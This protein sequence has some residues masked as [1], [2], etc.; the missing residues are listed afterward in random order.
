MKVIFLQ[1]VKGQGKANEVKEVSDGYARNYLFPNQLAKPA[2]AGA[3]KVLNL[4]KQIQAEEDQLAVAEMRQ[5]KQ[6]L[7]ELKPVFYLEVIN[8]KAQGAIT[9]KEVVSYLQE[10]EGVELSTKQLKNFN[11]L[12]ELGTF[13]VEI[14]LPMQ[15]KASL[16][17]M[18]ENK[19]QQK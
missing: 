19:N 15:V 11:N 16:T 17:I 10:K 1:E 5:L 2:T 13:L 6:K 18:V 9:A 8:N 12:K 7:E 4:K 3:T 14:N